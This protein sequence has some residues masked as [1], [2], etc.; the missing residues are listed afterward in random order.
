LF[1]GGLAAY[2]GELIST[3]VNFYLSVRQETLMYDSHIKWH[4]QVIFFRAWLYL[5]F[6]SGWGGVQQIQ[7]KTKGRE[8]GDLETVAPYSGVPLNLKMNETHILIRLLQMYFPWTWKF[9]SAL[10]KIRNFGGGGVELPKL[11]PPVCY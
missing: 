4:T 9:G 8:N 1:V 11:P 7:F 5:K 2:C 6:F 10:S 3:E